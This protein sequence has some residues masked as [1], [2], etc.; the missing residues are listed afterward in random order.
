MGGGMKRAPVK[1]RNLPH[2]V[3]AEAYAGY[4]LSN[5]G[6]WYSVGSERL[7]RQFPNSSG[8]YRPA[9]TVNG[10]RLRPFTHIKVVEIFGDCNGTRIPPNDGTLRELKLSID[11]LNRDKRNNRQSNLELV[12]HA[13]NCARKFK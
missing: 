5:M 9:L 8:Y 13:E 3:W 2:E 6:R 10:E 7:L 1:V 11:H 12:T 4:Y